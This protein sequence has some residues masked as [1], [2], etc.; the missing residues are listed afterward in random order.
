MSRL[1]THSEALGLARRAF[2]PIGVAS[3]LPGFS[4]PFRYAHSRSTALPQHRLRPPLLSEIQPRHFHACPRLRQEQEQQGQSQPLGEIKPRLSLTFTCT[5]AGCGHRSTHEFSK[6]AYTKGI[7]LVQCP[8]CHNRHLIADHLG[9]FTESS[10][11]PRTV[12]EMVAAKGG[13][14]KRGFKFSDGEGGHAI[15]IEPEDDSID[16]K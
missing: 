2:T 9:W 13:S 7:V 11:E 1:A 16:A 4:R 3:L 12:E 10:N 15:E 14:V 6:Q 5:A 8:G